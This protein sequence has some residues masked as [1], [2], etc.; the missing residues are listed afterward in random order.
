MASIHWSSNSP[1]PLFFHRAKKIAGI[2]SP[3]QSGLCNWR[4]I[5]AAF[6]RE[7][8]FFRRVIESANNKVLAVVALRTPRQFFVFIRK[9]L[10]DFR[11]W[12]VCTE[13]QW[14]W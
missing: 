10:H 5:E 9:P 12:D 7:T 4:R 13:R 14:D 3:T 11:P 1:E 8:R 6:K 2:L